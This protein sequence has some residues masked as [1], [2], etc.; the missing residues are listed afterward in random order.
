M[1]LIVRDAAGVWSS[2][3][4]ASYFHGERVTYA[5]LAVV[6]GLLAGL[7]ALTLSDSRSVEEHA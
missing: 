3:L 6:V 4:V 1:F 7:G 2:D 5:I